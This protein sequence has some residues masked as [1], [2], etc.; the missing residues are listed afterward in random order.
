[1]PFKEIS[2]KLY[3]KMGQLDLDDLDLMSMIF[4]TFG[5]DVWKMVKNCQKKVYI[6][7]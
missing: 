6:L 1:M 2:R 7:S 5:A 3:T 4:P